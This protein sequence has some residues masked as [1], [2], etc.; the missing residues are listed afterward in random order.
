ML[1]SFAK[2][3]DIHCGPGHA[4]ATLSRGVPTRRID[5]HCND[6]P[7]HQPPARGRRHGRSPL[8][9]EMLE[10]QTASSSDTYD[11]ADRFRPGAP[12]MLLTGVQAIARL[13]AEHR[14]L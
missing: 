5:I 13:L 3:E 2:T 9:T 6:R 12:P 11:L 4:T 8:M 14:A 7:D 1:H 10:R